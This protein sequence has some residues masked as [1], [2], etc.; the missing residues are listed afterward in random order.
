MK[1]Y[2]TQMFLAAIFMLTLISF[3]QYY[4]TR[5]EAKSEILVKA[6]RDLSE[7]QRVAAVRADV[8]SAVRN[9]TA[10]VERAINIPDL[11]YNIATQLV[12]TNP[13][14]VGAGVAFQPDYYKSQNKER[15]FAPYSY[16]ENPESEHESSNFK[17]QISS[18][19]LPFDYTTREWYRKPMT[20]GKSLWTQPYMDQ[21][22]THIVMVTYVVPIRDKS[23]HIAGVFFADVPLNDVSILSEKVYSGISR[24][25]MLM[26]GLQLLMF[27]V[28]GLVFWR[29]VR[30]SKR[31]KEHYVDPEKQHLQEQ[32]EKMKTINRRL[33]ERNMELAKK[34][35]TKDQHSDAHWFG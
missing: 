24:H 32:L 12:H 6:S 16:I 1:K 11:Y 17:P 27:L 2:T 18:R 29:A 30:A 35:Q 3:T 5:R 25:I 19:L 26:V 10:I 22:G 31:Y 21:G 34:L 13:H 4:I 9:T 8:E 23:N 28:I 7:N 33:T 14:I 20:N 15:L